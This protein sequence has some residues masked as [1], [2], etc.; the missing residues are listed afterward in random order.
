MMWNPIFSGSWRR[1]TPAFG[2]TIWPDLG[3]YFTE[4]KVAKDEE[5]ELKSFTEHGCWKSQLLENV[6]TQE[7]EEYIIN[8]IQPEVGGVNDKA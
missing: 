2:M 1:V 4:G 5:M 8:D 7:M 3:L 6:L